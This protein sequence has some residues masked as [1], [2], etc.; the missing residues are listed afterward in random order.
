MPHIFKIMNYLVQA[1]Y[2]DW[3]TPVHIEKDIVYKRALHGTF[4]VNLALSQN[5]F[6]IIIEAVKK[7]LQ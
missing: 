3:N 1:K 4:Y 5:Y 6:Y 2:L 7:G